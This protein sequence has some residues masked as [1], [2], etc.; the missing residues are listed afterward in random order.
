MK[1]ALS[2]GTSRMTSAASSLK[3]L[4]L[5]AYVERVLFPIRILSFR[6]SSTGLRN[7]NAKHFSGSTCCSD[8]LRGRNE[9]EEKG[10]GRKMR[11]SAAEGY[12]LLNS[13]LLPPRFSMSIMPDITISLSTA[14]HI[15]YTVNAATDTAVN[16]SISTP[17]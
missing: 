8:S 6:S 14:L 3:G 2:P 16:A 12:V 17:V 4:Y 11:F 9:R 7:Q 5:I 15:S 13:P 1:P 10:R